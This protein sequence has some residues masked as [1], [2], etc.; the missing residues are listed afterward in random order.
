MHIHTHTHNIVSYCIVLFFMQRIALR[1]IKLHFI[2][3]NRIV[4]CIVWRIVSFHIISY[5]IALH[6]IIYIIWL[7][8][9]RFGALLYVYTTYIKTCTK[10]QMKFIV[11]DLDFNVR[12][13][14]TM[15]K[16]MRTTTILFRK[17]VIYGPILH[18][19]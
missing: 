16:S 3:L 9:G 14:Y 8:T 12:V 19:V 17:T 7:L 2:I 6:C 4:S 18:N 5:C 10:C 15:C 1:H 11:Q 13:L